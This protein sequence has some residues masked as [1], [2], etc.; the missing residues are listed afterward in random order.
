M[1]ILNGNAA[2]VMVVA[3]GGLQHAGETYFE[4]LQVA[5]AA[6]ACLPETEWIREA[7]ALVVVARVLDDLSRRCL[8]A[9]PM[10]CVTEAMVVAATTAASKATSR[11]A[12]LQTM[13]DAMMTTIAEMTTCKPNGSSLVDWESELPDSFSTNAQALVER[14]Q[15]GRKVAA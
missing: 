4:R 11:D 8:V 1:L 3:K 12:V 9:K 14:R 2:A 6:I 13:L 15:H 5:L 10:L 7:D